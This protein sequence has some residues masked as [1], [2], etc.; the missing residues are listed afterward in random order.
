MTPSFLFSLLFVGDV[1]P[2][3]GQGG[4]AGRFERRRL[5][6]LHAQKEA[7]PTQLT[8]RMRSAWEPGR[9]RTHVLYRLSY[10]P[11][12]VGTAG[13]E[14]ATS[15]LGM[16]EPP[17]AHQAD[18]TVK[19]RTTAE[20]SPTSCEARLRTWTSGVRAR[21]GSRSTT[22]HRWDERPSGPN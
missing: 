16:K 12:G 21:R 19:D 9:R 17:S 3:R 8:G 13:L 1:V 14:P 5:A 20:A 18:S 6:A 2:V 10:V 11:R 7:R 22:S 4:R 15:S